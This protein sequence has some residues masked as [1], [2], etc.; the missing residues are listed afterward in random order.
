MRAALSQRR[1]FTRYLHYILTKSA[2]VVH[3]IHRFTVN[4][5]DRRKCNGVR[6][7][8]TKLIMTVCI[9]EQTVTLLLVCYSFQLSCIL[10]N[11][12]N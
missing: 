8:G 7:R 3:Y 10:D 9:L 12:I 11:G 2:L 1:T 4:E 5:K 6:V